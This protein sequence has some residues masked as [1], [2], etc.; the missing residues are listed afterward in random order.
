MTE[1]CAG[2]PPRSALRG[3]CPTCP[4]P[5]LR[6]WTY[7]TYNLRNLNKERAQPTHVQQR[8]NT[9]FFPLW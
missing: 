2:A 5:L 6:H 3:A 1:K 8:T 7:T 9:K 4:P